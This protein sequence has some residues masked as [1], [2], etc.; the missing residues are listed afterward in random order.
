[1][2]NIQCNK[3]RREKNTIQR[4]GKNRS[5]QQ[6][7]ATLPRQHQHVHGK[8]MKSRRVGM[9]PRTNSQ[10]DSHEHPVKIEKKGRDTI[11]FMSITCFQSLSQH[12]ERKK[13]YNKNSKPRLFLI[14]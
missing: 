2:V 11:I 14:P 9:N 13:E 12:R 3:G 1:M 5:K 4:N 10:C 6:T 8:I 7:L